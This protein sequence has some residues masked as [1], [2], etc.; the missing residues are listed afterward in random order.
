MNVTLQWLDKNYKRNPTLPVRWKAWWQK[1][2]SSGEE[3]IDD[4]CYWTNWQTGGNPCRIGFVCLVSAKQSTDVDYRTDV[5]S[6]VQKQKG[7]C[8]H[9]TLYPEALF[10]E[11]PQ[12]SPLL[13]R[14]PQ[15][16]PGLCRTIGK[17]GGTPYLLAGGQK[18]FQQVNWRS[19]LQSRC[20][21]ISGG[22]KGLGLTGRRFSL[23]Y[24]F[25]ARALKSWSSCGVER[26]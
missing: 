3:Q 15:R 19:N 4:C 25:S 7:Y 22:V 21:S 12:L 23:T 16:W 11:R 14:S 5:W 13:V 17:H 24:I 6:D 8:G 10:F 20:P 26:W 2:L 9:G 18:V 1:I